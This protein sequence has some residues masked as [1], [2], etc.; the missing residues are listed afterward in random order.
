MGFATGLDVKKRMKSIQQTKDCTTKK[1]EI[2]GCK[3]KA[4]FLLPL[5][6]ACVRA[7]LFFCW[8]FF[9]RLFPIAE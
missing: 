3:L 6:P 8:C 4:C 7:Q 5:P 1:A 9:F 2:I